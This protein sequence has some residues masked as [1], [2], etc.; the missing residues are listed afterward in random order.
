MKT[1]NL[2]LILAFLGCFA[3]A[4]DS[5]LYYVNDSIHS[6]IIYEGYYQN[7]FRND[8]SYAKV[9]FLTNRTEYYRAD[10]IYQITVLEPNAR[11]S[12]WLENDNWVMWN[13]VITF[14]GITEPYYKNRCKA[15]TTRRTRCKR[16]GDPFCWQHK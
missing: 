7:Y 12:Y 3:K 13:E 4:Q 2:I 15:L 6:K 1:F 14:D 11:F 9:K 10:T 16:K 5:T 8:N